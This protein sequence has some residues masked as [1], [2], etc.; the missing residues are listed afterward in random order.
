M[1]D[2]R[3][4]SAEF[5]VDVSCVGQTVPLS[6]VFFSLHCLVGTMHWLDGLGPSRERP[7]QDHR[8]F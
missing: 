6:Q 1:S 8:S 3:P 4:V 5:L 2:H 7:V